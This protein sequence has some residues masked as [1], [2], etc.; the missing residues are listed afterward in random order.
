MNEFHC[1]PFHSQI[2]SPPFFTS[3]S[4]YSFSFNMGNSQSSRGKDTGT[5]SVTE[6]E[7][8]FAALKE[9]ASRGNVMACYDAGFMMIQ[10]IGCWRDW[11]GGLELIKRGS[12]LEGAAKDESWKS[13]ES[14]TKLTGPQT[15]FLRGL[16]LVHLCCFWLTLPNVGTV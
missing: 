15:M 1:F 4:F 11:R 14:A 5:S 8:A 3:I 2:L 16:F 10:G 6:E 7:K 13:D 9:R 12:E